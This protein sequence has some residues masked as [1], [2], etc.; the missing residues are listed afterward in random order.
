MR[1]FVCVLA[2][3][4]VGGFCAAPARPGPPR[5]EQKQKQPNPYRLQ[6]MKAAISDIEAGKLK[7]KS[8]CSLTRRGTNGS[9]N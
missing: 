3:A 7:Q 8:V 5:A 6:G 1:V 9:S 4:V 2:V